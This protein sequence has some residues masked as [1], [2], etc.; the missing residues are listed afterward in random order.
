MADKHGWTIKDYRNALDALEL[1]VGELGIDELVRGWGEH[2][3]R[4]ELGVTLGTNCG[5]IYRVYDAYVV[6][7]RMMN[8]SKEQST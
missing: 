5:T 3:H 4:D 8:R 1:A 2:R 7:N 6:A